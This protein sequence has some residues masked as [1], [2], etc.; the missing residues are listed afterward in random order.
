MEIYEELLYSLVIGLL[1]MVLV[2]FFVVIWVLIGICRLYLILN[3]F[4]FIK[5]SISDVC[6]YYCRYVYSLVWFWF[7]FIEFRN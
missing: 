3:N 1:L 5:F 7:F 2:M 6:I 4:C